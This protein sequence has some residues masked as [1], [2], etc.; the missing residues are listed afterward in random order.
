M[1]LVLATGFA[2]LAGLLA[3]AALRDSGGS[4]G[5]TAVATLARVVASEDIPARTRIT[6][7]MVEVRA[8]PA[9]AALLGSFTES[10]AVLGLVT[11]YPIAANEQIG[12][13]KV[14]A[15]LAD[16]QTET[17]DSGLSFVI[18]QGFR[19][20]AI[21]VTESSAVGGLVVAGDHVDVIALFDKELTGLERAVTV[22]QNVEVLAVAQVAQEAVPPA[23]EAEGDET[24]AA[25]TGLGV[26]PL[27][28]EPQPSARTVTLAVSPEDA[29]ILALVEQ[30]ATL[31]L[32]LR[33]YEDDETPRITDSDLL[34]LGVLHP[35]LRD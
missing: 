24:G 3:Y 12:P 10:G 15:T 28:P 5:S 34:P 32:S 30:N 18:P 22:I 33:A 17:L 29:Q 31:W 13:Q 11:R 26:R 6:A 21:S 25:S 27:E 23:V 20:V 2:V 7:D 16:A 19:G 14:G 8:I 4:S 35:D 1:Y 9:E